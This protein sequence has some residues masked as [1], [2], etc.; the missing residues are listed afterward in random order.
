MKA[1]IFA[2]VHGN[3]LA[4]AQC[5]QTIAEM[6]VEETYFLGDLV[7]Y[8]P[9]EQECLDLLEVLEPRCQRGNHEEML[10]SPTAQSE[11]YDDVYGLRAARSRL[12]AEVLERLSTW[13]ARRERTIDGRRLL[14]VHGSP[15]RPLDGYV[16][17]DADLSAFETLPYDAVLMAHTHRPFVARVGGTLVANVGSVGLPRD[18]GAL[19]SFAIY[20]AASN[21]VRV[22]RLHMDVQAVLARWG[23]RM[24]DSTKQCLLRDAPQFVGEVIG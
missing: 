14:F 16:Y 4:L 2:D 22:L 7:G 6:D 13:P 21:D 3:S 18:V 20:D 9:G 24:H 8:L 17:P 1:A 10:L 15:S 12:G 23:A 11:D 5:V 19:C